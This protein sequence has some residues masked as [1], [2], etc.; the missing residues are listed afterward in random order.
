MKVILLEDVKSIG[1]AREIKEVKTGYAKNYLIKNSLAIEATKANIAKIE[2]DIKIEKEN[3]EK[4]LASAKVNKDKLEKLNIS[5]EVKSGPGG[6]L[7]G[8]I[9]AIDISNAIK[10]QGNI[11]ID[12]RKIIMDNIKDAG[13]HQV[14]IKLFEDVEAKINLDVIGK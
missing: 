4:L 9:T 14:K 5:V 10:T 7:Y 8:A 13:K 11:D 3:R 1:K 2:E 6:R 12:K